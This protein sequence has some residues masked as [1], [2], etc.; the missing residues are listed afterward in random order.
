MLRRRRERWPWQWVA[1]VG[2]VLVLASAGLCGSVPIAAASS[3]DAQATRAYLIAQYRL[4]TAV[5]RKA[6]AARGAERSAAAQVARECPGVV[7]G[8]PREPLGPLSLSARA[9]GENARLNQQRQTIE[10]DLPRMR[11]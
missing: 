3:S 4:V 6:A 7:S 2:A 10:G 8:M 5:L 11:C 1:R 9:R